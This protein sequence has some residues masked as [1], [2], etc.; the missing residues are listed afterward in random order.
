[1]DYIIY[2]LIE[3]KSADSVLVLSTYRRVEYLC[4]Y[5]K[6]YWY[7]DKLLE[8]EREQLW[9]WTSDSR[10]YTQLYTLN[11]VIYCS[12]CSDQLYVCGLGSASTAS[13]GNRKTDLLYR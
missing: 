6:T 1:M 10:S 2:A 5:K 4:R 7:F 12:K 8:S 9:S 11:E 13:H 3:L